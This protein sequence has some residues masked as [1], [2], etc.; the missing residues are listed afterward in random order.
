[1][2]L[3]GYGNATAQSYPILGTFEFIMNAD[4]GQLWDSIDATHFLSV[5]RNLDIPHLSKLLF[6]LSD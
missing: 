4:R 6:R 2:N 1:M 5:K 3:T